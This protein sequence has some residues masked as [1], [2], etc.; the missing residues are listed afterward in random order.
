MKIVDLQTTVLF[1]PFKRAISDAA[2]EIPGRDVLF[3]E[4]VTDSDITG[5]GF[6]TGLSVAHGSEI[7]IINEI[8]QQSLKP[9]VLG[10]DVFTI[11]N[12]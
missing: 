8:I 3:I 2:R 10:E 7:R 4:L 11:E 12:L 5:I 6:L 9:M 1:K